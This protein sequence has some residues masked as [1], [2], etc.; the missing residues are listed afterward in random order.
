MERTLKHPERGAIVLSR[1]GDVV[2]SVDA[3]GNVLVK[4]VCRTE[5]TAKAFEVW[6]LHHYADLG[7]KPHG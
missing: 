4:Q 6:L 3:Q 1:E 2:S 7:Y 5:I